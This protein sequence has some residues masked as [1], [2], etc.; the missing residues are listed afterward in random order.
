MKRDAEDYLS[1]WYAKK[2]RKPLV[3]RGA[4]QVGKSTLIRQ[5]A[6]NKQIKLLEIN[7][8]QHLYLGQIFKTLD[9]EQIVRELESLLGQPFLPKSHNFSGKK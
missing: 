9:I 5:F 7:L 1:K 6:K 2:N 3:L 4:R 8:E